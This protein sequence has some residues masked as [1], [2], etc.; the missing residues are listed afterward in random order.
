MLFIKTILI[1]I[2]DMIS[3]NGTFDVISEEEYQLL[4]KTMAFVPFHLCVFLL[5]NILMVSQLMLKVELLL[6]YKL[7]PTT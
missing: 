2:S 5:S 3:S 4:K 6:L 1:G 7:P